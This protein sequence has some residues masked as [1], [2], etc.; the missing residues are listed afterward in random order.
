MESEDIESILL[1]IVKEFSQP[2]N[3]QRILKEQVLANAIFYSFAV[4]ALKN[5]NGNEYETIENLRYVKKWIEEK[6]DILMGFTVS[7]E[8]E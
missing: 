7:D 8:N 3:F 1:M 5:A 4:G 6:Q 2:E